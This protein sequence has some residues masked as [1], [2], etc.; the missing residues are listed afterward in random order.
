MAATA[1]RTILPAARPPMAQ[2]PPTTVVTAVKLP[3]EPETPAAAP[4]PKPALAAAPAPKPALAAAPKPAFPA[5]PQPGSD[6]LHG[7]VPTEREGYGRCPHCQ[8]EFKIQTMLGHGGMCGH[9][10]RKPNLQKKTPKG[11]EKVHCPVCTKEVNQRTLD[12]YKGESCGACF[13][14]KSQVQLVFPLKCL[15]GCAANCASTEVKEKTYRKYFGICHPCAKEAA[16]QYV[17]HLNAEQTA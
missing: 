1:P 10:K 16:K 15:S 11:S 6:N 14:A 2:R 4:A 7:I 3:S 9:C 13:A 5:V 17:Q 8:R 12:K